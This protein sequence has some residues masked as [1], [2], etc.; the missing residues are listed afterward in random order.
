MPTPSSSDEFVDAR[1]LH[2]TC[3]PE[4]ERPSGWRTSEGD[5]IRGEDAVAAPD[6]IQQPSPPPSESQRSPGLSDTYS[7]DQRIKQIAM[8]E[9]M[10]TS[11]SEILSPVSMEETQEESEQS[12]H[13]G[14]SGGYTGGSSSMSNDFS[15]I[16]VR[17]SLPSWILRETRIDRLHSLCHLLPP[18]SCGPGANSVGRSNPSVKYMMYRLR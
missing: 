10:Q 3:P 15:N 7:N 14:S 13:R 1:S 8:A 4:D 12:D 16:R 17:F 6:V 5:G 18:R 11:S 2:S 9:E